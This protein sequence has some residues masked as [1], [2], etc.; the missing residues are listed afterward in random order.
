MSYSKVVSKE[1]ISGK[2]WQLN[3]EV[4]FRKLLIAT[5][6]KLTYNLPYN[7]TNNKYNEYMIKAFISHSSAQK[8]FVRSLEK[9]IGIDNCIV[10]ERTFESGKLIID[11]ITKSID[12]CEI[13]VFLI[14]KEALSS[15]PYP[16]FRTKIAAS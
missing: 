13:F 3:N 7:E 16:I 12:R 4:R 1:F 8:E 6:S 2:M 15:I 10:D 5:S 14:S 9:S 11:E